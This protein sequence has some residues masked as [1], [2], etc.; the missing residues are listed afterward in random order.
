MYK[1]LLL[2]FLFVPMAFWSCA[3]PSIVN[4]KKEKIKFH[5]N[6]AI[7][8]PRFEGNFNF[9]EESTDYFISLL[10]SKIGNKIIRDLA[11]R[12]ES[13]DVVS[14][15]NFAPRE[16][17]LKKA[18]IQGASLLVIGKVTSHST[19]G[20]LNGFSTIKVIDVETGEI[21]ANFH[22]PSG[23]LIGYSEHQCVMA[24]VKRTAQDLL[25]VLK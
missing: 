5:S 24:A 10:E 23:L 19:A 8:I 7:F 13:T 22:R 6:A 18:K 15:G 2:L 12:A 16:L 20:M 11:I 4:V 3:N 14:G 25:T 21:I 1:K 17:A 9:V